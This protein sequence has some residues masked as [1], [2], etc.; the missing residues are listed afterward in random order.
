MHWMIAEETVILRS[1]RKD[2]EENI[3]LRGSD[4]GAVEIRPANP[5]RRPPA[6]VV[7]T[8]VE[9]M[10]GINAESAGGDDAGEG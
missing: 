7:H 1:P 4:S 5:A 10:E 8:A 6:A 2:Y 9:M 3:V